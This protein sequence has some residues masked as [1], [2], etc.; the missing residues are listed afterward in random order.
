MC[1]Y[2]EHPLA[3]R[4]IQYRAPDNRSRYTLP[5]DKIKSNVQHPNNPGIPMILVIKN[6]IAFCNQVKVLGPLPNC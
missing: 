3:G 4:D 2:D 1:V 5:S 6:L